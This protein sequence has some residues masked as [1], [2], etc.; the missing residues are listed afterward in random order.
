MEA[1]QKGEYFWKRFHAIKSFNCFALAFLA[2]TNRLTEAK[3][4]R[5]KKSIYWN[6]LMTANEA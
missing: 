1:W 4:G 3:S 2:E 6:N 5:S